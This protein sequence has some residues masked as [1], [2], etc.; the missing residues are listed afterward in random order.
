MKLFIKKLIHLQDLYINIRITMDSN[1]C[2]VFICHIIT[3]HFKDNGFGND[4]KH[5]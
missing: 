1:G 2:S 3:I 4:S 5:Q